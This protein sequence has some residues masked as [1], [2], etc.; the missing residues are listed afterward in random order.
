MCF[1]HIHHHIL[2]FFSPLACSPFPPPNLISA[3][4][5]YETVKKNMCV[6][7]LSDF[8]LLSILYSSLGVS[9]FCEGKTRQKEIA[10]HLLCLNK[11]PMCLYVYFVLSSVNKHIGCFYKIVTVIM[12]Q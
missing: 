1:K 9:F 4:L 10:F 7:S 2:L 6:I 12:L 3:V 11:M 8:G 5:L